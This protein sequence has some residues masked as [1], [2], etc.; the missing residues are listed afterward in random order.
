MCAA[1]PLVNKAGT[2]IACTTQADAASR[3]A[4]TGATGGITGDGSSVPA[5]TSA[6]AVTSVAATPAS[7]S[8]AAGATFAATSGSGSG[9]L[10]QNGKDAQALNKQF[11]S[12]TADSSCTGKHS[13]IAPSPR[14]FHPLSH[15]IHPITSTPPHPIPSHPI[16]LIISSSP[17]RCAHSLCFLCPAADGQNACIGDAFVQCVGGKFVQSQCGGGLTCAALPLVNSAGTSIACVTQAEAASRIAATGA[18]GGV[19]G[20]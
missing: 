3:I 9:F 1:L 14:P 7:A 12:L 10:L 8:P 15:L 11:Q 5:S 20:N 4:A 19:T 18:T 13:S 6:G 17:E 16:Y 2:T